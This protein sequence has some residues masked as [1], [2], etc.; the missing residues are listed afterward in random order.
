MN[1]FSKVEIQG[2]V[3]KSSVLQIKGKASLN[4]AVCTSTVY[5]ETDTPLVVVTWIPVICHST[6][7]FP[8]TSDEVHIIGS[9]ISRKLVLSDGHETTQL[10][11]E[12]TQ[13]DILNAKE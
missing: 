6:E 3:G 8:K 4:M 2:V 9:L 11:V 10:Y 13:I 5:K 12:A 1:S 7:V